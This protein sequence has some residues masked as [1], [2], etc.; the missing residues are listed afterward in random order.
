[1]DEFDALIE[2]MSEQAWE[3][4][5][6]AVET[7]RWPDGRALKDGQRELC[8]QAVIAWEA[9]HLPEEARTGYLRR[10]DC[11]SDDAARPVT[12]R[13]KPKGGEHA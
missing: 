6:K 3:N 5:R 13:E 11:G 7:G 8:M 9:R 12:L 10:A 4:M 2:Q 1:M